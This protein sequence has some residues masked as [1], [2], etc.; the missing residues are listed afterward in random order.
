MIN[1]VNSAINF[2]GKVYVGGKT[3]EQ[4]RQ[5]KETIN[6]FEEPDQARINAGLDGLR[7]MLELQT[8]NEDT[9]EINFSYETTDD[10]FC[11]ALELSVGKNQGIIKTLRVDTDDMNPKNGYIRT[12]SPEDRTKAIT[13]IFSN[14]TRAMNRYVKEINYT[15]Q[16]EDG[17]S[18][19]IL[20]KLA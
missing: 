8:P 9:Y 16:E 18:D 10:D 2:A 14:M 15:P 1:K 7:E 3:L 12:F 4:K 19:Y 13:R 11:D 6:A 20:N 17:N 5:L